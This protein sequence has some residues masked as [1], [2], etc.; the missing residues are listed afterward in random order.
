MKSPIWMIAATMSA[1]MLMACASATAQD[2]GTRP[3]MLADSG[4]PAKTD[5]PPLPAGHPKVEPKQQ[6]PDLPAGHPKMPPAEEQPALPSG[7]PKVPGAGEQPA[8]PSGHPQIPPP[9][10]NGAL[11]A[12]HPGVGDPTAKG[13][14]TIKAVQSSKD[15]PAIGADVVILEYFNG[16]GQVV[17]RAESKLSDKGEVKVTGIP[18]GIPVQPLITIKHGGVEYRSAGNVMDAA[19]RDQD[20]EMHV[21]ESTTQEPAWQLRMRHVIVTPAPDGLAITEMVSVF[22]PGDRSWLGK[23]IG[24]GSPITLAVTLPPAA[25]K[26]QNSGG[27]TEADGKLVYGAA[28]QPG[29]A[30]FQYS[31]FLPAKNDSVD[32]NL[33]APAATGSIF[34]F[35]PEDGTTVT[36]TMLKKMEVKPGMNLRENSRFYTV[37]PQ[38]AGER[39]QF[40][41]S[42]LK[43]VKPAP[44]GATG[45]ADPVEGAGAPAA[46]VAGGKPSGIPDA[47]KIIGGVGAAAIVTVGV[48]VVMAK[49]KVSKVS[50]A[51]R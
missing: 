26:V 46:A 34:V 20:I 12:G 35:L 6:T 38:K 43:A 41:I 13:S 16:Q 25:Q 18:V 5:T 9:G 51:S 44:A 37:P 36:S 17:G 42:G 3:L 11:P 2:T 40:T 14:I 19:H 10:G 45:S 50:G 1:G 24:G 31:Y 4:E 8:L 49:G 48:V 22:N 32:V 28:L 39:I 23:A 15:A 7:H 33:E 27:L 21:F 29:T 47:A 30:E